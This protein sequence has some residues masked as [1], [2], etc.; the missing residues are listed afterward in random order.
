MDKGLF[1]ALTQSIAEMDQ[2]GRGRR[3][4]AHKADTASKQVKRIR[5]LTK[6]SQAKSA[7]NA[8]C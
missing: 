5:A 3:T 6:L 1:D 2:I 4:P 8:R 7:K